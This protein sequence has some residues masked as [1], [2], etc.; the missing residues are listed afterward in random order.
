MQIKIITK[1]TFQWL[2]TICLQL[3]KTD[4][5]DTEFFVEEGQ[6]D[7]ANGDENETENDEHMYANKI[8]NRVW[9]CMFNVSYQ[10]NGWVFLRNENK[11]QIQLVFK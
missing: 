6:F 4:V 5:T 3:H 8:D 9:R 2:V 7:S 10:Q 11:K 1:H